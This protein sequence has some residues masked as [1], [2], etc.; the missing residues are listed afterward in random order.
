M[1]CAWI[2]GCECKYKFREKAKAVGF[3][4]TL[5]FPD[6]YTPC[7]CTRDNVLNQLCLSSSS[8]SQKLPILDIYAS[9][10]QHIHRKHASLCDW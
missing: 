3:D 2:V 4:I 1:L 6:N 8:V 10:S 7:T 9:K 5:I